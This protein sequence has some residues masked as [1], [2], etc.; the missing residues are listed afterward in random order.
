MLASA[1]LAKARIQYG[2]I[3]QAW[4]CKSIL[5]SCLHRN[6]DHVLPTIVPPAKPRKPGCAGG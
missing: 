1:I 4:F 5:D 6:D 2:W 3:K